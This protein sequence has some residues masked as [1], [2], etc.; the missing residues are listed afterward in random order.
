MRH[1]ERRLQTEGDAAVFVGVP[2]DALVHVLVVAVVAT[3]CLVALCSLLSPWLLRSSSLLPS[4]PSFLS[5]VFS[6]FLT[7]RCD[8]LHKTERTK[9]RL[10]NLKKGESVNFFYWQT[11]LV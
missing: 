2:L 11:V 9:K 10:T 7:S 1:P 5:V 3:P 4:S 8:H 6:F